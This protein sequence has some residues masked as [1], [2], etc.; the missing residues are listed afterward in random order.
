MADSIPF[1][2]LLIGENAFYNQKDYQSNLERDLQ[3]KKPLPVVYRNETDSKI[4]RIALIIFYVICFPV[5]LY[6][7][8]HHVLGYLLVPA[9]AMRYQYEE[10]KIDL[11]HKIRK[12]AEQNK[13][14]NFRYH[15]KRISIEV[16]GEKIDAYIRGTE[17]TFRAGRWML[18]S[19]GNGDFAE[20]QVTTHAGSAPKLAEE[21]G[22]N[23]LS[24]NHPRTG[25]SSPLL[26][27]TTMAKVYKTMLK[28]LEDTDRGIGAKQIICYGHSIG[29]G[30]QA[31]GLDN[32]QLKKGIQY[33]SI[34]DRTFSSIYEAAV[35]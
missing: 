30:V 16:D 3:A 8:F 26:S 10:S 17:E 14:P 18:V 21:L 6:Q 27:R 12:E 20:T 24:F 29:G 1:S 11:Y 35:G 25:L 31:E 22:C 5:G 2:Q 33:L 23:I 13:L 4:H 7:G 32:Y 34:K 9:A 15:W 28:F 19:Q